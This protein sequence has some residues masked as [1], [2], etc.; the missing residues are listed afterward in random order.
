MVFIAVPGRAADV[1]MRIRRP[2]K[3]DHG[4][5]IPHLRP[6]T[7]SFSVEGPQQHPVWSD[8]NPRTRPVKR[9]GVAVLIGTA[10]HVYQAGRRTRGFWLGTDADCATAGAVTSKGKSPLAQPRT[11]NE[12]RNR[13]RSVLSVCLGRS[14]PA[15]SEASRGVPACASRALAKALTSISMVNSLHQGHTLI[16]RSGSLDLN[17]RTT[18]TTVALDLPAPDPRLISRVEPGTDLAQCAIA[19]PAH[20]SEPVG[21]DRQPV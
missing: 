7:R 4:A 12:S 2:G 3:H 19:P 13:R 1:K 16:P 6:N 11:D 5:R 10:Q 18:A 21:V 9:I 14:E 17:V 8:G 15:E 20:Q